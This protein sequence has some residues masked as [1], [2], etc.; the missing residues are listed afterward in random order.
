[1]KHAESPLSE[2]TV[3]VLAG[4]ATAWLEGHEFHDTDIGEPTPVD[5]RGEAVSLYI[6]GR[7]WAERKPDARVA[8]QS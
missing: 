8:R 2:L 3:T 1:M 6:L 5:A 7:A 4:C